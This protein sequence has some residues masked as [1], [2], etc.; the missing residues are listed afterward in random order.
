MR[1]LY[2]INADLE[3]LLSQVDENGELLIDDEALDALLMERTEK[4]EGVALAIKN[5]TAEAAAIKA[6]ETALKERRERLEK[7]ASGLTDWLRIALNGEKFETARCLV[8]YRKSEVVTIDEAVFFKRPPA[9]F[10]RKKIEADKTAIKAALK[11][12]E[13]IRGA[14]LE[15]KQNLQLK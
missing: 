15:E 6:E 13:T 4:L 11:A 1:A 7:K 3:A 5:I 8:T 14:T 9:K 12:G 10:I 2:E